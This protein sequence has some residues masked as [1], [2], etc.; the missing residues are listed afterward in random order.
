MR[1]SPARAEVSASKLTS[2]V[3]LG[4]GINALLPSPSG[5]LAW[6][7]TRTQIL[8]TSDSTLTSEGWT[9]SLTVSQVIFDPRVY[10]AVVTSFI[11]AGYYTTDAQDKQAKLIYDVTDSYLSLLGARLLRDATRSAL[12][13][14]DDNLKLNQEKERLGAASHIDVMRS[15]VFRSQA[16]I[17]LLTTENALVSANAGFLATAGISQDVVVKP[18][19]QLTQPSGFAISNNDS[20]VAEIERRN[21]G[22]QLAAKAGGIATVNTIATVGQVLPSVSAYWRSTYEDSSLP[23]SVRNWDDKDQITT[24]IGLT[25]PLLDLKSFVLDIADAVAG[26]RRTRAA[27]ARARYQIRAAATTAVLGYEKARQ[28]YDYAK[29]N[30]ELNQELYRLA[31][32]QQRLGAISLIDFFS[33]ETNLAQAQATYVSALTDTYV[34]AAQIAYLLGRT[35]PPER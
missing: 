24:G 28:S 8:P 15:Q 27:A 1:R 22:A 34:Q 14:A 16:E 11:N 29:R 20:L 19:E 25:F 18:T 3:K 12:D 10:A 30:L 13:R 31:Q 33:V 35:R 4:Q 26:S 23:R 6:G 2:G 7:K 9:G 21:P 17:Q 5:S 32:E